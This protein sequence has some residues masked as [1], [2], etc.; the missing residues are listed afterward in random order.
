MSGGLV[1]QGI[2]QGA[3]LVLVA[4][5]LALAVNALRDDGLP[6]QPRPAVKELKPGKA[7]A[8]SLPK[9]LNHFRSHT[10]LFLD[11]RETYEFEAG[12]IPGA[13]NVST[14]AGADLPA[15]LQGRPEHLIIT[16]CS[17]A[18][19]SK[20]EKL[21]AE[22]T[23]AGITNVRIMREGWLGWSNAGFPVEGHP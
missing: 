7:S 4:A 20:A 3:V 18:E 13:W 11:A 23:Q 16:Y 10:A 14:G 5:V 12:H 19:C 6:L 21:A 8:I 9:A 2:W 17:D 15:R 1:K 22:L